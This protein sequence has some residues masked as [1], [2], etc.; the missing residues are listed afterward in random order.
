[1][2]ST[3]LMFHVTY[4]PVFGMTL[5]TKYLVPKAWVM[6][7]KLVDHPEQTQPKVIA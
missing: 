4:E 5:G 1:M 6:H 3:P 2:V 7:L